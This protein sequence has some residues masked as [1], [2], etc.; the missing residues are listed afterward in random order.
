[1]ERLKK[2]GGV[3]R[4]RHSSVRALDVPHQQIQAA[5]TA[6]RSDPSVQFA[7]LDGLAKTVYMP[8][9]PIV[10]GKQAWHLERIG[11]LKAWDFTTGSEGVLVA[12]LDTGVGCD[13]P[14]LYGRVI[15]GEDFVNGD[16]DPADDLGHG[17]AVTGVIVARGNN[18]V[19]TAGVSFGSSVLAVKVADAS[20]F[21]AY[22][23]IAE[24]IVYAVNC[25]A[26]IINL[27]VAGTLPS[28]TLQDAVDFA[29]S[30]GVLVVAASGNNGNSTPLYPAACAG[31]LSVGATSPDDLRASFSNYGSSLQLTAPGDG[32]WTTQNDPA[33][34]F[35]AWRGTSFAAPV[36]CGVAALALS[37]A[38]SM[39]LSDLEALLRASTDDLGAPGWDPQ[40]G[41]GRINACK[42][43]ST[44]V[45]TPLL[46]DPEP[47]PVAE[48]VEDTEAPV[49]RIG[50]GPAHRARVEQDVVTYLGTA[51]DNM[52]V[53]G[54]EVCI[55]GETIHAEGT[56]NWSVSVP[57][58]A[59]TNW[60][61]FCAIDGGGNRSREIRRAVFRSVKAVLRVES[62][63]GGRVAPDLDG[64]EL[65]VGRAYLVRAVA[66]SGNILASWGDEPASGS[67]LRFVMEEGLVLRPAFVAN[68]F[69]RVKGAY[70]GLVAG[71][72]DGGPEN[73]GYF[74]LQVG[75]GGA[76][77]GVVLMG[78][79]RMPFSG[80]FFSDGRAEVLIRRK[81]LEALTARFEVDFG[82]GRVAGELNDGTREAELLAM[83][84]EY[85]AVRNPAPQA[86]RRAFLLKAESEGGGVDAGGGLGRITR[87]GGALVTGALSN[88]R[89]F[90]MRS[91]LDRLGNYPFYL[92]Y[93]RGAEVL[94]GWVNFPIHEQEGVTG[95]VL[96][97]ATGT[98]S[99]ATALKV[100]G[101]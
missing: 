91:S 23:D 61:A 29:R 68:P 41:W 28:A 84:N 65:E 44:L 42:L 76:Y 43:V 15:P 97:M 83:R 14:D 74:A 35:V 94:I 48:S 100:A 55:N 20:G 46:P 77:S 6:L 25:G 40:F 10:S 79:R 36:V 67:V 69:P 50:T 7:E 80:R 13:H 3:R 101:F 39:P 85:H 17:T 38:P 21:A 45:G 86:G 92:S 24:G 57:L 2:H 22:S 18:Q 63:V 4:M 53:G 72:G 58:L 93:N 98:N 59:G 95:Q 52:E 78:G 99:F 32:I 11:V 70:A 37:L 47:D 12:V 88:G 31:V 54:V 64:K 60:V 8:D 49:I 19:G 16:S 9:D 33:R 1:M 81:S 90:A 34:P 56:S 62:G 71:Q 66:E 89:R 51:A 73:S 82:G 87:G 30:C 75:G 5:L 27:S 26:R 96:W